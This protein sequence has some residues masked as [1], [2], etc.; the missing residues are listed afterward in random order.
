MTDSLHRKLWRRLAKAFG[1]Y[2]DD[3]AALRLAA[4]ATLYIPWDAVDPACTLSLRRLARRVGLPRDQTVLC[5]ERLKRLGLVEHS[6][7]A[8]FV[9]LDLR[10]LLQ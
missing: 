3:A 1:E 8:G 5:L 2:P 10:P 6:I 4:A 7:T 9:D